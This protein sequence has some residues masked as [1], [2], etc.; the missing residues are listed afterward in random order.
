MHTKF[1]DF[2]A[3]AK[4]AKFSSR[5]SWAVIK[6]SSDTYW[7]QITQVLKYIIITFKISKFHFT[8]PEDRPTFAEL[9]VML[10]DVHNYMMKEERNP[11]PPP[12]CP[13][14]HPL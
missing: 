5:N 7:I 9:T 2:D 8:R 13:P 14:R 3:P 6:T 4:I 12:I 11:A 1:S 10:R